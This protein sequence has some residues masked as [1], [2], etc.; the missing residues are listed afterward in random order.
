YLNRESG[1]TMLAVALGANYPFR[2]IA[3]AMAS[4][5]KYH[6]N[7]DALR[8][9]SA[10]IPN[11]VLAASGENL[12][13]VLDAIFT[14]P[15]RSL[16]GVLESSLHGAIPTLHGIDLPVTNA[17][18]KSVGFSLIGESQSLVP[19]P[20]QL[21]SDG[22]LLVTAFLALAYGNTPNLLFVEEPEN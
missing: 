7:P 2:L 14:G 3:D 10:P 11:P 4:T 19:I 20:S 18:A 6:F 17:P 5:A 16:R 12:A 22:A 13:S 15:N 9:S 1:K 21:A 8:K